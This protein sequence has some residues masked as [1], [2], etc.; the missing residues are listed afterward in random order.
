MPKSETSAFGL[1]ESTAFDPA[2]RQQLIDL[3][4]T[5]LSRLETANTLEPQQRARY[6]SA[7]NALLHD[8]MYAVSQMSKY[9]VSD[10]I[11]YAEDKK[12]TLK[13][14][15]EALFQSETYAQQL[16]RCQI[17]VIQG[18][19]AGVLSGFR[20]LRNAVLSLALQSGDGT[21]EE[22]AESWWNRQF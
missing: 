6:E 11:T 14:Q 2:I 18:D 3:I 9:A 19:W 16:E 1:T 17:A 20:Y 10:G 13:T 15:L 8:T 7:Y 12:D 21:V 4:R 5:N 22:D